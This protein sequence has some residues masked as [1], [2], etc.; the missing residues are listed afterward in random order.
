[1][2]VL[3]PRVNYAR[4]DVNNWQGKII[5]QLMARKPIVAVRW[6]NTTMEFCSQQGCQTFTC[7]FFC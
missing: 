3:L 4:V 5:I 6:C 7:I 1:M 2:R